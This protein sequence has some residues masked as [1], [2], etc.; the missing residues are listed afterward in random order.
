MTR[1]TRDTYDPFH[2]RQNAEPSA[3]HRHHESSTGGQQ[4]PPEDP[5]GRP[6]AA[7]RVYGNKVTQPRV[8]SELASEFDPVGG[9]TSVAIFP[10]SGVPLFATWLCGVPRHL[11]AMCG[12][13][14]KPPDAH[15]GYPSHEEHD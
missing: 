5:H 15:P 12:S 2:R 14:H 4:S 10:S 8:F 6:D 7:G 1:N 13:K 11:I 3:R 9:R